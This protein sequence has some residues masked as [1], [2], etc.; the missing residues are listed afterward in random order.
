MRSF[1]LLIAQALLLYIGLVAAQTYTVTNNCP[2][3]IGPGQSVVKTGLGTF[4]G[5]FYTTTHSA[6]RPVGELARAGF[7]FEP[8]YWYYY[9]VKDPDFLN[10][11]ISITPDQP[12]NGPFCTV[13]ACETVDCNTAY[14]SPPVFHGP[15]PPP[16]DMIPVP[17]VYQCKVPG[18]NFRITFCPSGNWPR[19][20]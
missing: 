4:A 8:N 11:G 20:R 16:P 5:F 13:A 14:T 10:T 19:R 9:L 18:T 7:Y 12:V 6:G 3:A 1:L 15:V 17:P 2:S